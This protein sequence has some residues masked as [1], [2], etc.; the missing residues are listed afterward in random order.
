MV[1]YLHLILGIEE[2]AAM[3]SC[4]DLVIEDSHTK[5]SDVFYSQAK[6]LPA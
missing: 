1:F 3:L 2:S 5:L 4:N 6:N